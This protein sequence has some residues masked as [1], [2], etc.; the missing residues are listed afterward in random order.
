MFRNAN[1]MHRY[2]F[3][4]TT[5][6]GRPFYPAQDALDGFTPESVAP[7]APARGGTSL[8]K[9]RLSRVSKTNLGS[10]GLVHRDMEGK[11]S[12][13]ATPPST[14]NAKALTPPA[15]PPSLASF[16]SEKK[17]RK[18]IDFGPNE[19]RLGVLP[20]TSEK[21]CEAGAPSTRNKNDAHGAAQH[22]ASHKRPSATLDTYL[23]PDPKR[24]KSADS[25][26]AEPSRSEST[27]AKKNRAQFVVKLYDMLNAQQN[28]DIVSWY[29][30]G[31]VIW[32]R[33]R[34]ASTVL[35]LLFNHQKFSSFERQMNFYSFSKMAVS[36]DFSS[37]RRMKKTDPTKWKHRLF[38][39]GM[40][41]QNIAGI[42]RTTDPGK[43]REI[44]KSLELVKSRNVTVSKKLTNLTNIAQQLETDLAALPQLPAEGTLGPNTVS[45]T[46][47]TLPTIYSV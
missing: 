13:G 23:L 34:F 18:W 27:S 8:R 15:T 31:F 40:S 24:R 10:A 19:E 32:N 16:S 26:N 4:H 22:A 6:C 20:Q 33:S 25:P 17:K 21:K 47:L 38:F 12:R 29:A 28:A 36:D 37:T 3:R 41:K 39:K 9:V 7:A 30:D 1:S 44:K 46:H 43:V 11:A 14:P 2:A 42:K 35:P 45:Y 5:G